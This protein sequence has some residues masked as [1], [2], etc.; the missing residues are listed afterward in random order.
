[1]NFRMWIAVLGLLLLA[2]DG[3]ALVPERR[4]DFDDRT[5][6]EYLIVPAVASI[7]GVGTFIGVISS[8][9]NLGDTGI[10]LG[11]VVAESIDGS[12]I[13]ITAIAF[14]ELPLGIP[15]LTVDVQW[16]DISL[17]NLDVYLPG[18]DS[19]N[20]TI[21]I[22]AEFQFVLL[23]P[24][25]RLFERRFRLVYSLGFLDGF[26][27]NDEG[28]EIPF[29]QHTL[30]WSAE[31][32]L[33]DDVVDPRLGVR[34]G[35]GS[36][37]TP[38][39]SSFLGR[40]TETD[41]AFSL[42]EGV[43]LRQ[44]SLT[45]YIPVSERINL[46]WNNLFFE[47]SG[48]GEGGT[49]GDIIAGGSPPLRGFPADRWRDRFAVFHGFELRYSIPFGIDLD[50]LLARGV[51]EE[52]QAAVFYEVGQVSPRND[53]SLYEDMHDSYGVG[54]RLLLQAIVLR[55]DLAI[56]SEGPQTHLTIGHAF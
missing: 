14:R 56:G 45:F 20:F 52:I 48:G 12:D 2:S 53:S 24:T 21:P 55:F 18:R 27:F 10:D 49:G 31:L 33:T 13:N 15:G 8:F 30:S 37:L 36:T 51:L 17:G 34:L 16:A 32:D 29:A 42:E 5:P 1:M 25:L 9:S 39:D 38:P 26:D 7:P 43:Q 46:A 35:F 19:P 41:S 3:M 22:T 44:T 28:N 11:A 54:I 50:F 6:N 4:R 47:T 40:N 23:Q